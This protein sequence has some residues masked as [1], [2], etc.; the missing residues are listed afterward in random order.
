MK[1]ICYFKGF[2]INTQRNQV[3]TGKSDNVPLYRNIG[4]KVKWA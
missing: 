2:R 4:W 3:E 1:I